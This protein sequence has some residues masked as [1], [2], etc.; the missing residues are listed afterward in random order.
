MEP[1]ETFGKVLARLMQSKGCSMKELAARMDIKSPNAI[2]RITGDKSSLRKIEAF[3]KE[4]LEKNA[5]FLV[6]YE[7]EELRQALI[8]SKMGESAYATNRQMLGFVREL[9]QGP[10]CVCQKAFGEDC[11]FIVSLGDLLQSY[12]QYDQVDIML[13]SS[14][15]SGVTRALK[16]LLENQ[17]NSAI[18]VEHYVITSQDSANQVTDFI[19]LLDVMGHPNYHFYFSPQCMHMGHNMFNAY[20][21]L[22]V[23]LKRGRDGRLWTDV[24]RFHTQD[25]F[26]LLHNVEGEA[27]YQFNLAQ[28]QTM[29]LQ[30]NPA[31]A[32]LSSELSFSGMLEYASKLL[33]LDLQLP[34]FSVH[35][36][37]RLCMIPPDITAS[38]A[39]IAAFDKAGDSAAAHRR[40][41]HVANQ[42]YHLFTNPGRPRRYLF[43]KSG[44][45]Y[46]LQ[47]GES[48]ANVFG[49]R[50]FTMEERRR[51]IE[52]MI[53]VAKTVPSTTFHLLKNELHYNYVSYLLYGDKTLL[54]DNYQGFHNFDPTG[55]YHS[56][57][58]QSMDIT[59]SFAYFAE[60]DLLELYTHTNEETL[61]F[62]EKLLQ[63]TH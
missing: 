47:S 1:I 21:N 51:V 61:V 6:E 53:R 49:L 35:P 45:C 42:R 11:L 31:K 12:R 54:I 52:G 4:L 41:L 34:I 38:L 48:Q 39:D 10:D 63:D 36:D 56:C 19:N 46:F 23:A 9:P 40:Y 62:L 18:Q 24:V 17:G 25:R 59:K 29:R 14:A 43:S 55:R 60:H 33:E 27:T 32:T 16:T 37:I 22:M 58:I 8:V 28:F 5:L 15:I 44:M 2:A 57:C 30:H 26:D 13:Q 50:E 7:K 20:S 3:C